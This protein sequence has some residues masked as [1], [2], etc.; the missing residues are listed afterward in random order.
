MYS[1]ALLIAIYLTSKLATVLFQSS[2]VVAKYTVK[3]G[4]KLI[5]KTA[6]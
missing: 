1:Q 5:Q 6:S 2:E 3:L 4:Q